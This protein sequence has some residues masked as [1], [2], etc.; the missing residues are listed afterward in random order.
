M[1]NTGS[2]MKAANKIKLNKQKSG[3]MMATGI[4]TKQQDGL[5]SQ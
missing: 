2:Y 5:D 4:A 3:N 1:P